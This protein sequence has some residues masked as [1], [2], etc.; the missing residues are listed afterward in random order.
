MDWVVLPGLLMLAASTVQSSR[1]VENPKNYQSSTG[2]TRSLA[3]S[4]PA[5]VAFHP[6]A[7]PLG[8]FVG[9][10]TIGSRPARWLRQAEESF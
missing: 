9:A 6:E 1:T 4:K 10:T 7:L 3:T 2:S 8:L 5:W